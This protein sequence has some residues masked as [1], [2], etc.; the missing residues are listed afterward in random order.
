MYAQSFRGWRVRRVSLARLA[1]IDVESVQCD[2][3]S[4]DE[5]ADSSGHCFLRRGSHFLPVECRSTDTPR[6][7]CRILSDIP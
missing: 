3:C 6:G 7:I 1:R 4:R 5:A 2:E